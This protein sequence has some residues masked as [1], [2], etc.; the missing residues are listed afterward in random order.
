[1][2]S[3]TFTAKCNVKDGRCTEKQNPI[4]GAARLGGR[5]E[6]NGCVSIEWCCSSLPTGPDPLLI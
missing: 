6:I 2:F 5:G 3:V 4:R 1:M